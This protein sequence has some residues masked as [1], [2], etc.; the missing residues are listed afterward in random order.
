MPTCKSCGTSISDQQAVGSL[1]DL[2]FLPGPDGKR[3]GRKMARKRASDVGPL[4][5]ECLE[6]QE[7][8]PP[9]AAGGA[10][11]PQ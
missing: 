7:R 6:R 11:G 2:R 10:N 8:L 1:F 3:L 5:S 4:C 9:P